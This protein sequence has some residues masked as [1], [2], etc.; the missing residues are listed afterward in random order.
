MVPLIVAVAVTGQCN[1]Y[2]AQTYV[3]TYTPQAYAYYSC[4]SPSRDHRAGRLYP[5][6]QS[7]NRVGSTCT[8]AWSAA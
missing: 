8:M 1:A 4:H 5:I 3:Q 7:A 2:R 6:R